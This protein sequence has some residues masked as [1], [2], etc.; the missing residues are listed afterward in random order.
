MSNGGTEQRGGLFR[1]FF[2]GGR[3]R[4]A[5]DPRE[6]EVA[7]IRG[8][9]REDVVPILQW[10]SNPDVASHLDPV[11]EVPKD[12]NDARQV[13]EAKTKLYDYYMNNGEPSKI[14]PVVVENVL[15]QPIAVTT[16]RLKGDFHVQGRSGRDRRIASDE[17]TIVDPRV[18]E[19]GIGTLTLAATASIALDRID[20]Y[21]G[22]PA[23]ELRLWIMSDAKAAG[24][25][26]NLNLTARL[27]FVPVQ[28]E[29]VTWHEFGED[30][31][32]RTDRRATW[33][34]LKPEAWERFKANYPDIMGKV[35]KFLDVASLRNSPRSL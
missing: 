18:W 19:K 7:S 33:M 11:P 16:I 6:W 24:Y 8:F 17:R 35:N 30:R 10:S 3:E 31:G 9:R 4:E 34:T 22:R 21:N 12:W 14:I 29:N 32:I 23:E 1:G 15:R 20:V 5:V 28:G 25:D 26:R 2:G 13:E 27:G